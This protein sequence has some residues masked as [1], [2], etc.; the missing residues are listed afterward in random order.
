MD[1]LL[2]YG[3]H[4]LDT[5]VYFERAFSKKNKIDYC[6]PS[7]RL[8]RKGYEKNIDL[9]S[10]LQKN[11]KKY[12]LFFYIDSY[13]PGFPRGIEKLSF[14]TACYLIDVPYDLKQRLLQI[15]FFD[16]VFT[17]HIQFLK[18]FRKVNKNS[19][20]LPFAAD[21]K[22]NFLI[23][24]EKKEYDIGF[25][26]G[27][28]NEKRGKILENLARRFKINNFR[29]FYSVEEMNKVYNRSKIVFNM[30]RRGELNMR[31]FEAMA[32][33][34][35]LLTSDFWGREE[36]FKD[37]KHLVVFNN[38]KDL[39]EKIEYYL[40]NPEERKRIAEEG[41]KEILAKH[42]YLHR[43]ETVIKTIRDHNWDMLAPARFWSKDRIFLGYVKVYTKLGFFDSLC[44][45]FFSFKTKMLTKFI[46]F[47]YILRAIIRKLRINRN[48]I[49]KFLKFK[50]TI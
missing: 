17:P 48:L 7:F 34:S 31:V 27:T 11:K 14:P 26:G 1:I 44:D 4:P 18:N 9:F 16:Y 49:T 8:K 21:P 3:Y 35:M 36:I 32:S 20:W 41:R 19:F 15:S 47:L 2:Y 12:D 5:G 28:R 45:L 38:E 39:V 50:K 46:G 6:G 40:S 25:V 42:T 23:K 24:N 29:K 33:G 13:M 37:K 22:T 43:V 30:P 10:C